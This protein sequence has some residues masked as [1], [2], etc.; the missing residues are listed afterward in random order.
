M[1]KFSAM[2]EHDDPH[3]DRGNSRGYES[4]KLPPCRGK[5]KEK[6]DGKHEKFYASRSNASGD[7][8]SR[9]VP[10]CGQRKMRKN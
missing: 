2:R 5:G 10:R 8:S 6:K 4:S 3:D 7:E 1:E 9:S